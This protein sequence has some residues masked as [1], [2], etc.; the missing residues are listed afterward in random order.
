MAIMFFSSFT[1]SAGFSAFGY[2]RFRYYKQGEQNAIKQSQ[3]LWYN[4]RAQAGRNLF[5]V[6]LGIGA[7]IYIYNLINAA[8]A[9]NPWLL[10]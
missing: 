4:E 6:S 9:E 3:I 8:T 5:F 10:E 2:D 7:G 1:I